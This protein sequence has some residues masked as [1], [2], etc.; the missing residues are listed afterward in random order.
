MQTKFFGRNALGGVFCAL[1]AGLVFVIASCGGDGNDPDEGGSSSS[2]TKPPMSTITHSDIDIRTLSLA[3]HSA[4]E[5]HVNINVSVDLNST[6]PEITGFDSVL[7]KLNGRLLNEDK[8][9]GVNSRYFTYKN[10]GADRINIQDVFGLGA[11]GSTISLSVQ[12]Y[13]FGNKAVAAQKDTS[14]VKQND[15]GYCKSSASVEISSSSVVVIKPFIPVMFGNA[16]SVLIRSGEG[17]NL[18]T[19]GS[20]T[21]ITFDWGSREITVGGSM[22]SIIGSFET[23]SGCT[24]KQASA[25]RDSTDGY[26]PCPSGDPQTSAQCNSYSYLVRSTATASATYW[27]P[28]WYLIRCRQE[29]TASGAII[30]VWKVN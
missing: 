4:Q 7:V 12:V 14:L 30:R 29:T 24:T 22:S 19:G 10:D 28:G 23:E 3:W 15:V 16:D 1:F 20:G 9:I 8:G 18:A 26:L 5:S 13:A 21:D 11:C 25:Q 2:G 27:V 6:D 17:I